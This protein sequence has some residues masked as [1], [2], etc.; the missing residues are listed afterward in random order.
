MNQFT[1]STLP[2]PPISVDESTRSCE[3]VVATSA[4]IGGISLRVAPDAIQ[5]GPAPVPVLMD[6]QNATAAMCGR[7]TA[8]RTAG[9]QVIGTAVFADAPAADAGW[10]LAQAGCAV[11]VGALVQPDD[12]APLDATADRAARWTLREVSLVPVGADPAC[13]VRSQS[14]PP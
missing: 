11:S 1:V 5:F 12:L 14:L 6:H 10:A 9:D 8:I 2:G 7:I 4:A 3:L 13:V